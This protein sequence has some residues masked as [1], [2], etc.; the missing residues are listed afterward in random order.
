VR[1]A[2]S[3]FYFGTLYISV[4]NGARKLKFGTRVTIYAYKRPV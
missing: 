1:S 2:A 3:S 4:T